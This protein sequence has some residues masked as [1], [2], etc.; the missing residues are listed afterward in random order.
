MSGRIQFPCTI[1]GRL[2]SGDI[3]A[4]VSPNR[5]LKTYA[6][7]LTVNTTG[8][9]LDTDQ[10][11]SSQFWNVSQW[12]VEVLLPD[13][14]FA[15]S[16]GYSDTAWLFMLMPQSLVG[17]PA[18]SVN[19]Q[20]LP[21]QVITKNLGIVV[22]NS[23]VD[24][25]NGQTASATDGDLHSSNPINEQQRFQIPPLWFFRALYV[26]NDQASGVAMAAGTQIRISLSVSIVPIPD[27]L[28][29]T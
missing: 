26:F 8:F 28:Q 16:V 20:I 9:F 12:S 6:T 3:D 25:A 10:V 2:A 23:T 17:A 4:L 14:Q 1:N 15:V 11:P 7:E 13:S 24:V 19:P 29:A 18:F 21:S 22:G 5:Q 27:F